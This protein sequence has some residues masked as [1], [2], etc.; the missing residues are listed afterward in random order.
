MALWYLVIPA[1]YCSHFSRGRPNLSLSEYKLMSLSASYMFCHLIL[2]AR[3]WAW[4]GSG[5][6]GEEV[7]LPSCHRLVVW[8]KSQPQLSCLSSF[9]ITVS[10]SS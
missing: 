1:P 2:T 5:P 10:I 7:S 3:P 8:A 9:L 6:S 4:L